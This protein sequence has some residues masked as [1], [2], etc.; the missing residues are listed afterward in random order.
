MALTEAQEDAVG[1]VDELVELAAA[2]NWTAEKRGLSETHAWVHLAHPW[3]LPVQAFYAI[4]DEANRDVFIYGSLAFGQSALRGLIEGESEA[5]LRPV[6]VG[7]GLSEDDALG[8]LQVINDR[9]LDYVTGNESPVPPIVPPTNAAHQQVVPPTVPPTVHEAASA[10]H[11]KASAAHS[12]AHQAYE[13]EHSAAHMASN[14]PPTEDD[15]LD[16]E[17]R[18]WIAQEASEH[19]RQ[20]GDPACQQDTYAAVEAQQRM[21]AAR[22]WSGVASPM[23]NDELLA[24]VLGKTIRFRNRVSGRI[25]DAVVSTARE[26]KNHVPKITPIGFDTED[27]EKNED[28]RILH[29]LEPGGGFRSIA[30]SQITEIN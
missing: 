26:A 1:L 15:D 21:G 16:A 5:D 24:Y 3:K 10:A 19:M 2:S 4:D 6:F 11:S 14:V 23:S 8:Q 27:A 7:M 12:A 30:V 29:F 22:N 25:D 9:L 28:L 17:D 18:R 20:A 13:H